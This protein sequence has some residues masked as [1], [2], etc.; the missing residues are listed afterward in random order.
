VEGGRTEGD[1]KKFG[2]DERESV[3]NGVWV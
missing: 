1:E 2:E 3:Q